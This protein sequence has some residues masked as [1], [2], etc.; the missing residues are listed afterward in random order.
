MSGGEGG[1]SDNQFYTVDGGVGGSGCTSKQPDF[2]GWTWVSV[3][4][5]RFQTASSW[6]TGLYVCVQIPLRDTS[7]RLTGVYVCVQI[8]WPD[9]Q[10]MVDLGVCVCLD[11]AS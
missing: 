6:L 3:S 7:S 8:P 9:S 11:S 5:F 4:V 10:F 1:E 2:H